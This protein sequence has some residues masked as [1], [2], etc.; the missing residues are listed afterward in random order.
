MKYTQGQLQNKFFSAPGM[1]GKAYAMHSIK[2]SFITQDMNEQI[3]GGKVEAT[4]SRGHISLIWGPNWQK[5][6]SNERYGH[7][8]SID[9]LWVIVALMVW[10]LQRCKVRHFYKI[11]KMAEN[12]A[13]FLSAENLFFGQFFSKCSHFKTKKASCLKPTSDGHK[14]PKFS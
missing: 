13:I 12:W 6:L 7:F 2:D 3:R 9:T 5:M 8:L 1:F 11:L 10:A 4:F 14:Y